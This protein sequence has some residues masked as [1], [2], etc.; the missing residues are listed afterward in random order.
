[1]DIF[2]VDVVLQLLC[3]SRLVCVFD[4]GLVTGVGKLG[5]GG[6]RQHG[7]GSTQGCL[8]GSGVGPELNINIRP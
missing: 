7:V 2:G 6:A 3:R 8:G 1:M 4:L 5:L